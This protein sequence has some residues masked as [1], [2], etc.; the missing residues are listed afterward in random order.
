MRLASAHVVNYKRFT[1]LT[2]ED[3]PRYNQVGCTRG[4]ERVG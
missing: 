4:P 3:L 1:D 2:I